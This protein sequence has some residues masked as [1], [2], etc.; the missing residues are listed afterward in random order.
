[1]IRPLGPDVV[2]SR[3]KKPGNVFSKPMQNHPDL[4][5]L[6]VDD[7]AIT[8]NIIY[9]YTDVRKNYLT[10][11]NRINSSWCVS[12]CGLLT[13]QNITIKLL[14]VLIILCFCLVQLS[15]ASCHCR[16][17]LVTPRDQQSLSPEGGR[18]GGISLRAII[19]F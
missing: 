19:W 15:S 16:D 12:V 4:W 9:K 17:W 13:L 7:N 6:K 11:N 1:M 3:E 14:L 10:L 8:L 2:N 18:G 5:S